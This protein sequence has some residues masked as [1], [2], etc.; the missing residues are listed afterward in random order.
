M[1][2]QGQSR[3][4]LRH[5]FSLV[6]A[7]ILFL[8]FGQLIAQQPPSASDFSRR[9][10]AWEV[11]L[12]PSGEFVAL[13]IPS[14]DGLETQLEITNL[15]T[16]DTQVLR[17]GQRFHVSD[18]IWT[19]DDQV[20]VSRAEL[21]PLK[22]R[23]VS[24]GHLYTSDIRGKNRDVLFGYI[25]DNGT[26]RGRRKDQGWSSVI[27]VLNNEPGMAL[28]RFTCWNCGENPDTVIF[29]VNTRTGDRQE[30]ER[31]AM[32]A[33]FQFD[34]AGKARFRTTYNEDNEP[35]L[36]YRRNPGDDW[37]PLPK[38]IAGRLLYGARFASDNN[39][40]YAL[41]TD[42]LEPAQAYKIDLKAGTRTLLAGS[43][44]VAVSD[45][46]YEGM[47]G[48]P[49]AVTFDEAKPSLQYIDPG[50]PWAQL[51]AGL[52]KSFPG[53]MLDFINFSRDGNK[54]LF[55][56]WSDRDIGSY[57]VYDRT[58]KQAQKIIDYKPWL[59]PE[60][61]AQMRSI[62][63]VNRSGQTIHGFYTAIGTGPKPLVVMAH[64][65]P[66]GVYDQW[67][68]DS[69]VQY[70]A[71]HGYAVLQVNYRGSGGRG[72][73]FERAGWLGWGT[74][75]QDDI[76]DG[77]RWAIQQQ[78]ADPQRICTYGGSF[79]GYTALI[80]PILNPGMYKCAIGY[81]GVYDL[82]LMR[83]TDANRG[84]SERTERFFNRT[85]GTDMA[86][87]AQ[88][89]PTTRVADLR[90]P[91][92]LAHGKDDQTANFNQFKAM[93]GALEAQGR[94]A[95]VFAV[96]GEGHGFVNPDNRA[97]MYRRVQLFLDRY[98]GPGSH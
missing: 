74:T 9:P 55:R 50:S 61:M 79:G 19:A 49:F 37:A 54:I 94:P 30:I 51:H 8:P 4:S 11:S 64:G 60:S 66:F 90:V 26:R 56:V 21:E 46:M 22:A 28:V 5:V 32:R 52:M 3:Q 87:L 83:R 88:F 59:K 53:H 95:E 10:T 42:A 18:V 89:S 97:E 70:L 72:E 44:N 76:T 92:M 24:M 40:V 84:V 77:V 2:L 57:Y 36:S 35:E 69:D 82:P 33:G 80:Q 96:P 78:L 7:T 48:I 58:S 29:K 93:V 81:V 13:A 23:P 20:V 68:F 39:T 62:E 73:A 86:A 75:I 45:F 67:G 65:G 6:L 31:G 63:F 34:R 17:F 47:D 14:Q 1:L 43:P 25:R 71:T 41:V 98:I 12:S 91:V 38:S 16:G 85:L 27:K 15:A